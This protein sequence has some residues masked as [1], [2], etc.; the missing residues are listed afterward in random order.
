VL[1]NDSLVFNAAVF[2]SEIENYQQQVRIVDEYTTQ[3]N[4]DA[5]TPATAYTAATGNVPQVTVKGVEIDGVYAGIPNTQI[6]FSG[7]YN[8]AYYASFPNLAQP[9]ENGFIGADPYRDA[10]GE[11]LPGSFKYAFNL[12]LDYRVP[13]SSGLELHT[14]ANAAYQ[15]KF[16]GDIALSSYAWLPGRTLV[17]LSL[18]LGTRSG[19]FDV[20]LLLKNALDD[21]TRVAQT[22]NSY[23]PA[24]PR[25]WGVMFSGKL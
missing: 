17:D 10:S 8:D 16:N 11:T 2:Y 12:G 23:S 6:R 4:T 25:W 21:D 9:V 3:L 7:A 20:S 14:S 18:G 19:S 5:G 24:F 1:F 15:S 22:W 13:V